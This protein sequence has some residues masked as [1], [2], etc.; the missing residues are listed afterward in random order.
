[1]TTCISS[2][3]WAFR[4]SRSDFSR[5][6]GRPRASRRASKEALL[7]M[8]ALRGVSTPALM[9]RSG[10]ERAASRSTRAAVICFQGSA[11]LRGW[12]WRQG[13]LRLRRLRLG[14]A[15]ISRVLCVADHCSLMFECQNIA[16]SWH[17]PKRSSTR[18]SGKTW[19]LVSIA[20][21][22][23]KMPIPNAIAVKATG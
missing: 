8:R 15:A 5:D 20:K 9:L 16:L 22:T 6:T 12:R 17:K 7:S 18:Q 23:T 11:R 21:G 3:R 2:T 10:A 19:P 13:L 4:S 1:M 14:R